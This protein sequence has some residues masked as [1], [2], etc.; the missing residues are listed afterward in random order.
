MGTTRST[1]TMQGEK[2]ALSRRVEKHWRL[3]GWGQI[4]KGEH[5]TYASKSAD[6]AGCYVNSFVSC[7]MSWSDVL[8]ISRDVCIALL[9]RAAPQ[10][11]QLRSPDLRHAWSLCKRLYF[12]CGTGL[13]FTSRATEQR[14]VPHR[15]CIQQSPAE[16]TNS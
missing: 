15:H 9:C 1:S 12:Q 6:S 10:S 8:V 13:T 16:A 3:I 11:G 2:I 14:L 5:V 7:H 4:Q